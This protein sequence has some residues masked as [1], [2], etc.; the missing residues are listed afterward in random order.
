MV[1]NGI[2]QR[3]RLLKR[4]HPLRDLRT[5]PRDKHIQEVDVGQLLGEH[6]ALMDTKLASKRLL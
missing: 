1:R 3:H 2:E 6:K 5:D 4:A